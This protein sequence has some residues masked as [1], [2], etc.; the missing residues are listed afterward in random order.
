MNSQLEQKTTT[1]N[2]IREVYYH[3]NTIRACQ[4]LKTMFVNSKLDIHKHKSL[5]E[6]S[7]AIKLNMVCTAIA[8]EQKCNEVSTYMPQDESQ[9]SV[10]FWRQRDQHTGLKV[11]TTFKIVL[12]SHYNKQATVGKHMST[13]VFFFEHTIPFF[14]LQVW[15][16]LYQI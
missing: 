15:I 11:E 4:H 3:E 14:R 2:K 8:T 5:G 12:Y 10:N 9:S 13:S 1:S 7:K 6:Q 16:G